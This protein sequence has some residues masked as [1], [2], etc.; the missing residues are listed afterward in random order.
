[1]HRSWIL[2]FVFV[3]SGCVNRPSVMDDVKYWVEDVELQFSG[4][5]ESFLSEESVRLK[6]LSGLRKQFEVRGLTATNKDS[7]DFTLNTKIVYERFIQDDK[8]T[9][10]AMGDAYLANVV[11]GYEAKLLDRNGIE[12]IF[13][14]PAQRMHA[15]GSMHDMQMLLTVVR[16]M[17]N[18]NS[19][20]VYIKKIPG[21]IVHKILAGPL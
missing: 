3:L 19:E 16:R 11:V 18:N 5:H 13:S 14:M 8:I 20:D 17:A 6:L 9:S 4:A 12:L 15:K 1:M 10:F 2:L 7:A 21:L